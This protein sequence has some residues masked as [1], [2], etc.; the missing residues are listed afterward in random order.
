MIYFPNA[1]INIGLFVTG[2]REDGF[3]NIESV[4]YPIGLNDALEMR[5]VTKERYDLKT[6]ETKLYLSGENTGNSIS[7]DQNNTVLKAFNLLQRD[8]KQISNMNIC[9]HKRIPVFAGLGGGSSDGT[10]TILLMNYMFNLK[11]DSNQMYSYAVKIGSDCPFFLKN[12]PQ[13][14]YSR[15]EKMEDINLS[16]NGYHLVLIKPNINISTKEAYQ[17]VYKTTHPLDLKKLRVENISQWKNYVSND[18]E[19]RLFE[20]YPL[21]GQIKNILYDNGALYAQMSGSGSTIY[22]IFEQEIDLNK[23]DLPVNM[24]VYQEVLGK[25]TVG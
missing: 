11:L 7:N 10:F 24:F 6:G 2:K 3:H 9:L 4:F 25:N 22:G 5:P 14:V 23:L 19:I 1:K 17:D 16:L 18:F 8:F 21:L 13:F 15:G 20:K 12:T